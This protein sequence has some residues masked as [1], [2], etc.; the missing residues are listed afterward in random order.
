MHAPS[1][2]VICRTVVVLGYLTALA[3]VGTPGPAAAGVAAALVGV[4]VVPLITG[5]LH[6]RPALEPAPAAA[7][8]PSGAVAT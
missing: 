5:H 3:L 1:I 8:E 2:P 4:W 7:P 6:V